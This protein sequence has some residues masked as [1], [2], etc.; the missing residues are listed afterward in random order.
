VNVVRN[1]EEEFF[2]NGA[3]GAYSHLHEKMGTRYLQ[4]F[5]NRYENKK[6]PGS[7]PSPGKLGDRKKGSIS[8]NREC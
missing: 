8:A 5:L 3:N 6:I 1:A 2:R 4:K 7:I